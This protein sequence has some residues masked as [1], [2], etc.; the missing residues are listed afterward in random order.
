MRTEDLLRFEAEW[1]VIRQRLRPTRVEAVFF[2]PSSPTYLAGGPDRPPTQRLAQA[3]AG[4]VRF[5][6]GAAERG[7]LDDVQRPRERPTTPSEL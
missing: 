4:F 2:R 5:P 7:F 3:R 6:K 1:R